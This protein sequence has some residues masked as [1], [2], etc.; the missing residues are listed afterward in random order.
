MNATNQFHETW[1]NYLKATAKTWWAK[2]HIDAD[3]AY[4]ELLV[5]YAIAVQ[6]YNA[7]SG[8][9]FDTFF[10]SYRKKALNK[11]I[12]EAKN[13]KG[14]GIFLVCMDDVSE[15]SKDTMKSI[16]DGLL[17]RLSSVTLSRDAQRMLNVILNEDLIGDRNN[18]RIGKITVLDKANEVLGI[19]YNRGRELLKEIDQFYKEYC[20]A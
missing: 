10:Y 20:I 12:T 19:S 16:I 5:E 15:L 1:M 13:W 3:E 6:K 2:Y 11:L 9:K 4:S 7:N 8:I 14:D 18:S 17:L